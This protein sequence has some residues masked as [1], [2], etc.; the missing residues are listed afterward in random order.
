MSIPNNFDFHHGLLEAAHEAGVIHRDLKPANIK[1][2]EDGTVKVLDFGLA[3]ALDTTP[4]GDPSLSPTLTA[5]ATQMGVIM[6]TAAYMSPEQ[7]AGKPVDRRGDI[8]SF[9]VVLFEMLTGKRLFMGERVSHVLGAVLQVDPNWEAPP[10]QTP[11][12]VKRLLSRC[13]NKDRKQRLQHIGDARVEIT[14]VLAAPPRELVA[15]G[16]PRARSNTHRPWQLA[17]VV[18]SIATILLYAQSQGG[19]GSGTDASLPRQISRTVV[20]L[21]VQVS[22]F[23]GAGAP[24]I[25]FESPALALSPDGSQLVYV[26]RADSSTRLYHRDLDSF[27]EP[28]P[29]LGTEGALY[30][31]V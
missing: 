6:G 12:P 29:L 1:V 11:Q 2:R 16:A 31:A 13:L 19:S 9:G 22:L 25:G 18:L 8:W 5:A 21:P 10:T 7:A 3:K 23:V 27:A 26:G 4:E 14:D 30:G 17:T 24:L 20:D 15:P 28:R